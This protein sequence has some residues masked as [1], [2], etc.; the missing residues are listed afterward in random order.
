MGRFLSVV[1]SMTFEGHKVIAMVQ[2]VQRQHWCPGL[3]K[4][5]P[6]RGW[7][8]WKGRVITNK[9]ML[10]DFHGLHDTENP[11]FT[12]IHHLCFS[13]NER[14]SRLVIL[15][16]KQPF[17]VKSHGKKFPWHFTQTEIVHAVNHNL[18]DIPVSNEILNYMHSCK[19]SSV[20]HL[21]GEPELT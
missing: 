21:L 8:G 2:A 12:Q 18:S 20:T 15:Y 13:V 17:W 16:E 10:T 4:Y 5:L 3:K 11:Q 6:M 7:S 19:L 9:N 1:P 14:N